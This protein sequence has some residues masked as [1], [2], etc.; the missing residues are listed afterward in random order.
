[1]SARPIV[2]GDYLVEKAIRLRVILI[3]QSGHGR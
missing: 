1:M 2:T 3:E